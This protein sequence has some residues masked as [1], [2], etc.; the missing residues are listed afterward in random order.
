MQEKESL[1]SNLD[2]L[3][4]IITDCKNATSVSENHYRNTKDTEGITKPNISGVMYISNDEDHLI[5]ETNEETGLGIKEI[6]AFFPNL[7]LYAKHIRESNIVKYIYRYEGRD[8]EIDLIRYGSNITHPNSI[9]NEL[10]IR[11]N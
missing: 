2:L 6:Q 3:R 10:F 7:K 11:N 5:D 9:T 8:E 4:L 1:I